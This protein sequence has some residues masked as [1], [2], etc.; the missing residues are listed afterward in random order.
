MVVSENTNKI[1]LYAQEEAGRLN[2]ACIEPAHLLLAIIR[3]GDGSAYN[4]LAQAGLDPEQA[5]EALEQS[6]TGIRQQAPELHLRTYLPY[7]GGYQSGIP[8]GDGLLGAH[9]AGHPERT[10][11]QDGRLSGARMENLI[12]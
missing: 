7:R 1:I 11:Q 3:L 12:Q 10:Y 9:A 4:L 5:K 8:L 6:V 2:S